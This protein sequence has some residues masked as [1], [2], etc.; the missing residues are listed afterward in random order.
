MRKV[1]RGC[2]TRQSA[3]PR[4][5]A[6]S[7]RS[8]PKRP[9]RPGSVGAVPRPSCDGR[10]RP[11][12]R[13]RPRP[14]TALSGTSGRRV[15]GRVAEREGQSPGAHARPCPHPA[16]PPAPPRG[17][18]AAPARAGPEW[19]LSIGIK[20]A[21]LSAEP[22]ASAKAGRP[23]AVRPLRQPPAVNTS[24]GLRRR[25]SGLGPCAQVANVP[26]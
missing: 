8:E 26:P 19:Q 13:P 15:A 18:P 6:S 2:G 12:P 7:A 3:R 14:A 1:G 5:G 10:S 25:A 4:G 11:S 21:R 9:R 22:F 24:P 16:R 23:Q 20:R 17:S